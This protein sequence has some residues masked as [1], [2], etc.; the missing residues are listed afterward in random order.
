MRFISSIFRKVASLRSA[1]LVVD[2]SYY[3]SLYPDVKAAG[4]SAEDHFRVNG[5]REGRNPSPFFHTLYYVAKYLGNEL[6]TNPLQDFVVAPGRCSKPETIEEWE[7]IQSDYIRPYFD[8]SHYLLSC[9]ESLENIDLV[10]HYVSKG[11]S[12]GYDPTPDFKTSE[13]QL[14]HRHVVAS[15][16]N[17]FYHAL[18]VNGFRP[19]SSKLLGNA[20]A[21]PVISSIPQSSAVQNV[22]VDIDNKTLSRLAVMREIAPYF[23]AGFYISNNPD[24]E[25]AG[26]NPL[27]H[28][29]DYGW[30]ENRN[31][32]SVFDTRYYRE[33][34]QN[35][36]AADENPLYHYA[37]K[38]IRAGYR[39][40]PVGTRLWL[41][42]T[43]PESTDWVH[44]S[45]AR[46]G[47]DSQV[48][49]IIPVY[50]GYDDTLATIYS[51][52]TASRRTPFALLVIND[53][54]PQPELTEALRVLAKRELFDYV[55][56]ES[57]LGF[58][59]TI[60]VGLA[61]CK[62]DVIL[63]NAD[64]LVHGDWVDRLLAHAKAEPRLAT[65]T[66]FSNNA[67][68]CSYPDFARQNILALECSLAEVDDYA[69]A[70]NRQRRVVVPTGVGF[71]FYM[72]R[73]VID[74]IGGLDPAFGRG[75][76]E[77]NDFCMR[78]L[79]A[80][81]V[82]V[83]A[84]DIFVYHSGEVSFAE[85]K[86]KEYG[87]GQEVML[88]KHPDYARRV[89][90][91]INSDPGKF[92]RAR[93]DLYRLARRLGNKTAVLMSFEGSGG[94]VTH[95]NI[96]A[97]R[98]QS[99][100][101]DVLFLFA[102]GS[103]V[104]LRP[105][106]EEL[107]VYRPSVSSIRVDADGAL[108]QEFLVWLNPQFIHL[109][110]LAHAGWRSTRSIMTTLSQLPFPLYVTLHDFDCLCHRHNMVDEEGLFCEK[111]EESRCLAC[112]RRDRTGVDHVNP[113]ERHAA[114]DAFLRVARQ[115]FVPS[116]DTKNR[117][118]CYFPG[119]EFTVR[120]HEERL[121][122][123][124]PLASL[125]DTGNMKIVAIGAVGP[126]KGSN[127]LHA[128]SLDAKQR[129]LPITYHIVGYSNL[130]AELRAVGCDET[131][132]YDSDSECIKNLEAIQPTFA[133]FPSIWP[134]THCYAL[135]MAMAL[136]I[137]PIVFD[138]GAQAERVRACGYGYI[139]A[140]EMIYSPQE[141]NDFILSLSKAQAWLA[142]RPALFPTYP[143]FPNDY[144]N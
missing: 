108:L 118:S 142:R 17:P 44:V 134:E 97:E 9:G 117:L 129:G 100:G 40:N 7:E 64:T 39:P 101:Y 121:A 71:C 18:L 38:G 23:D 62:G 34:Y 131:G 41:R 19:A 126:H 139:L 12:L 133:F 79:K 141:I 76:G 81:Y 20:N 70:A 84:E 1:A 3:W 33:R 4:V 91:F 96:L 52:L 51:V 50:R 8:E 119:L 127:L 57:N 36:L 75:Y 29:V 116:E 106:R 107:D 88:S 83:M 73:S 45:P 109:H 24:V 85:F 144:Y 120:P 135:S 80:G 74:A 63:L 128:L 55:E 103:F 89:Q 14:N 58:I 53:C 13:Y 30:K 16:V 95:L 130:T 5:W 35:A 132:R 111:I 2:A 136:Q 105:A 25:R 54:G 65:I 82:N 37:I 138:I 48:T 66:P 43:A 113:H 143:A 6:H 67:S 125:T 22:T 115:V 112:V 61:L 11:A 122:N 102:H 72:R 93:L 15:Q 87:A 42:P 137:P 92:G 86:D 110:S 60:N 56:N 21:S 140:R 69:A 49:I 10:R 27:L 59:G 31:P 26:L 77:E 94:V 124:R 28:F 104:R 68:I 32:S 98:L 99:S 78:A 114:W 123:I 46:S 47:P 90:S